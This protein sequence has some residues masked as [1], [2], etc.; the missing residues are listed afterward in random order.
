M[1]G[2]R[3]NFLLLK[4]QEKGIIETKKEFCDLLGFDYGSLG[5]Y[6]SGKVNVV[7]NENNIKKYKKAGI[8]I[9][10]LLTGEGEMFRGETR[11]VEYMPVAE[12]SKIP[13]LRQTVS[14]GPGQEWETGDNVESYIE[15]LGLVTDKKQLCAFR[16]RGVSMIGAG[17]QD[18]DILIFDG[19]RNQSLHDDIYMFGFN[20]EA[21]CKFLRFDVFAGKIHIYSVHQ[22]DLDK[23]ELIKTV[24]SSTDGFQIFGRVICWIHE[25]RLMWRG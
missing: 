7:I 1:T 9:D 18:G 16:S 24:D 19:D 14:C 22:K 6:L 4:M 8:N 3:L 17:I 23:A 20:G 25:N 2:N 11:N 12:S 21:F 13:L 5:K 10:W 15:P